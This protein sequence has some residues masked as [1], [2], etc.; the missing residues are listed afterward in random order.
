[1]KAASS[2]SV[3]VP[4]MTMRPPNHSTSAVEAMTKIVMVGMKK[5]QVLTMRTRETRF[6][7]IVVGFSSLKD[8]KERNFF[9]N[10]PTSFFLADSAVDRL[11][12]VGGRLLQESP[13][14]RSFLQDLRT[15]RPAP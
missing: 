4:A 9:M 11:R 12:E 1:M 6:Y 14:Y 3:S 13:I 10:Q 5:P 7:P 8:P 15:S 2:P